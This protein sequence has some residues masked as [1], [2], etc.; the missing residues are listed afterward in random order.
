MEDYP[1]CQLQ[2]W[3]LGWQGHHAHVPTSPILSHE[4]LAS[5]PAPPLVLQTGSFLFGRTNI[6]LTAHL[7][8]GLAQW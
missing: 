4:P 7:L 8:G 1:P 6:Y 5:D 2:T 3:V